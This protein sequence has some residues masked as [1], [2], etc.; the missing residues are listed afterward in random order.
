MFSLSRD[1]SLLLSLLSLL[2][3]TSSFPVPWRRDDPEL[4]HQ[5][6]H[7][8]FDTLLHD[9]AIHDPVDVRAGYGLV[10]RDGLGITSPS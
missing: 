1:G 10:G 3:F 2:S 7:V 4:L 8:N 9:L 5:A 6:K